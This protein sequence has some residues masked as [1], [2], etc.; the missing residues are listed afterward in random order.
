MCLNCVFI[1]Q[2]KI[3]CIKNI[4]ATLTHL[5]SVVY[6]TKLA[7]N[8]AIGGNMFDKIIGRR[9]SVQIDDKGQWNELKNFCTE[10]K[11]R[12]VRYNAC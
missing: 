9:I 7:I 6:Y 8:S 12:L 5:D 1:S 2:L 4:C 11:I 10:N 3:N